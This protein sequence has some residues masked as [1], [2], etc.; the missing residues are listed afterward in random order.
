M[1]SEYVEYLPLFVQQNFILV[2][3]LNLLDPKPQVDDTA[4]EMHVSRAMSPY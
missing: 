3:A 2:K 4:I 1:I